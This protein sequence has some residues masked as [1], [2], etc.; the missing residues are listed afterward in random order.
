MSFPF[1]LNPDNPGRWDRE[2]LA[3][4]LWVAQLIAEANGAV[5]LSEVAL[6]ARLFPDDVLRGFGIIDTSGK[7]TRLWDEARR[8]AI[9]HLHA[10][11]TTEQKLELVTVFHQVCMADDE[12]VQSELLVLR[13]AA[14]ALG[15]AVRDLSAHLRK[16]AT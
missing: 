9:R 11:L 13:E 15:V 1:D 3:F 6:M 10:E 2:K 5:D 8:D 12:L 14:E 4:S 16:L 7:L